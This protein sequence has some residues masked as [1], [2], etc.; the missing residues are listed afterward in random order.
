[1]IAVLVV[2]MGNFCLQS[3]SLEAAQV[4]G[5]AINDK[6]GIYQLALEVI[7]NA[8]SDDVHHVITDY[9]HIYRI[10][11]SIVESGIMGKPGASVTRVR[12]VINDCVLLLCRPI[13]RV[14]DVRETGHDDIYSV[15]VPQLSNVRSGT[16]H[17]QIHPIGNKTR[18]NYKSTLEPG[19]FVPPLV[20]STV[21]EKKIRDETLLCFNNIER[22][23]RIRDEQVRAHN[24]TTSDTHAKHTGS[25]HDEAN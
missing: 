1:M 12:T 22:I 20:G 11:P 15:V 5:L 6:E 10:D 14:E 19:F 8:R 23:A 7:L 13:L 4:V 25:K 9:A 2:A 18:I 17:W 24:A 21:V 16:E 3:T